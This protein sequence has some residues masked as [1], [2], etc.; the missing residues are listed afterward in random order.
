MH[1]FNALN[2]CVVFLDRGWFVVIK[3]W[4]RRAGIAQLVEQLIRNQ[5]VSGSSP[6]AGS[7]LS[8]LFQGRQFCRRQ[9]L[10]SSIG[11]LKNSTFHFAAA[12]RD[13]NR[14]VIG[15]PFA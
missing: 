14:S 1:D 9:S 2:Q 11:S 5:Q 3:K 8:I 6:L 4:P 12:I 7:K 13:F 15:R 10:L